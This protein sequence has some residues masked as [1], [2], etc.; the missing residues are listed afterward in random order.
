MFC[1]A[2]LSIKFAYPLLVALDLRSRRLSIPAYLMPVTNPCG[3][4]IVSLTSPLSNITCQIVSTHKTMR[5][6]EERT[7][8]LIFFIRLTY[9]PL[10]IKNT[11]FFA[12]REFKALLCFCD[13]SGC[14]TL[15][16]LLRKNQPFANNQI[17]GKPK[18]AEYPFHYFMLLFLGKHV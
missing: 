12:M 15:I 9:D 3:F 1:M 11:F 5:K 17:K 18:K 6:W 8:E 7:D 10:S 4:D 13:F 16:N 14:Q 2:T